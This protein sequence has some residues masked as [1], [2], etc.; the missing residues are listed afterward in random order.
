MKS[1][2]LFFGAGKRRGVKDISGVP[3]Q[4]VQAELELL[5]S[6]RI[7]IMRSRKVAFEEISPSDLLMVEEGNPFLQRVDLQPLDDPHRIPEG[8]LMRRRCHTREDNGLLK[9][10]G[11]QEQRVVSDE[12]SFRG[13]EWRPDRMIAQGR[14]SAGAGSLNDC[15]TFGSKDV[16][17]HTS[18]AHRFVGT[19]NEI[20]A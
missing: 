7:K 14:I 18:E 16:G 1:K 20:V 13:N 4:L 8:D 3:P 6:A 9:I 12:A 5:F 11:S 19:L 15:P 17:A 10:N 2:D